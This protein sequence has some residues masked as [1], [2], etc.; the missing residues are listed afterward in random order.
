VTF[1]AV[2]VALPLLALAL[3][4]LAYYSWSGWRYYQAHQAEFVGG[5]FIRDDPQVGYLLRPGAAI[6]HA[7]APEFGVY[8]DGAGC[9]AD[10]PGRP[11]PS[12]VDLLAVGCSFT[13]GYGVDNE[14]T[15]VSRVAEAT[16]QRACNAAVPAHG[17]T[18]ARL[19]IDRY[20]GLAPKVI[21]YGFIGTHEVR[22][23]LPCATTS[24]P[25]CRSVAFVDARAGTP[26]IVA[27]TGAGEAEGRYLADTL[28]RHGFG[29][30]DVY[31]AMMR[32]WYR[33]TGRSAEAVNGPYLAQAADGPARRQ[34]VAFLLDEMAS[35]ARELGARLV[36]A[37]IPIPGDVRPM[38]ASLAAALAAH[39][40]LAHADLEPAFRAYEALH[41]PGSLRVAPDDAHP[42]AE[43]HRLIAE[44]VAPLVAGSPA[45]P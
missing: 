24:E 42:N 23:L 36:V 5:S 34:A 32:D 29:P 9:R 14:D 10:G 20:A 19:A 35:R 7:T 45:T 33:L 17:T 31:W 22:N 40:E 44:A 27:P 43:G 38:P 15:F 8:A 16:G 4:G 39:P 2:L 6:R 11:A 28:T 13:F 30:R 3:V 37:Y 1:T 18:A 26:R 41:G 21:L 25:F 12:Q